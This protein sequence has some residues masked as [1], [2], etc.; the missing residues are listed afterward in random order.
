MKIT[1]DTR[2]RTINIDTGV[3]RTNNMVDRNGRPH[4]PEGTSKGGQFAPKGGASGGTSKQQKIDADT[5]NFGH[6][7]DKLLRGELG[8][9]E[10]LQI[11]SIVPSVYQKLGFKRL[12]VK[13]TQKIFHKVTHG[14][15]CVP[16][17]VMRQMPT[18][19]RDPAYIF[20]SDSH[21]EDGSV[22]IVTDKKDMD[23]DRI[24][25]VMRP[26]SDGTFHTIPSAY[27]KQRFEQFFKNNIEKNL[28]YKKQE[29]L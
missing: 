27:G 17:N 2:T 8:W 24:I 25:V 19:M 23:G 9:H 20:K 3:F 13:I 28:L 26:A 11:Y 12:P 4:V 7:I 29:S 22:V 15:H 21:P 5:K 1:I 16:L 6:Q 14:Q 10:Q 18:I